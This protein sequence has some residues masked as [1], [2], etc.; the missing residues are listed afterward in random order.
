MFAQA[1]KLPAMPK[2]RLAELYRQ[3]SSGEIPVG[4]STGTVIVFVG[5]FL[6]KWIASLVKWLPWQGKVFY[7]DKGVLRNT[8]TILVSA[9]LQ[10]GFI[11][12]LTGWMATQRSCSLIPKR[13]WW[14]G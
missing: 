9:A 2:A 6:T 4:D 7:P 3:S 11:G 10:R 8:I 13:P 5:L 12:T 1:S 14:H